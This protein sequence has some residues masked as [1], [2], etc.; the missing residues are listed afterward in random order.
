MRVS[1]RPSM[2]PDREVDL[3]QALV[4]AVAHELWKACGGNEVVNWLEA[5]RIVARLIGGQAEP[6]RAPRSRR[7]E[8]RARRPVRKTEN[9]RLNGPIPYF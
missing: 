1:V 9:E 5:E 8:G 7:A 2:A 4:G 6:R 3:T